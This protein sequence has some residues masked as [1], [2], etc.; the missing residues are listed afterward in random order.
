[1]EDLEVRIYGGGQDALDA[2]SELL[3]Q[4]FDSS[5]FKPEEGC[6]VVVRCVM[7]DTGDEWVGV[8]Q[9][10]DDNGWMNIRQHYAKTITHWA[11]IP[12]FPDEDGGS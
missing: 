11:Y 10:S 8:T 6:L 9:Y 2:A 5:E 12:D 3:P 7:P 4:W 1:M